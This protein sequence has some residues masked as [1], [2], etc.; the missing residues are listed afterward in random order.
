MKLIRLLGQL[1]FGKLSG[2]AVW[3]VSVPPPADMSVDGYLGDLEMVT[4]Q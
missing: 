2:K 4:M 1:K 3:A